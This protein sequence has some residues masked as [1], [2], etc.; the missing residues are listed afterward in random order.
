MNAKI[1]IFLTILLIAILPACAPAASP[2]QPANHTNVEEVQVSAAGAPAPTAASLAYAQSEAAANLANTQT[3]GAVI[4]SNPQAAGRMVIKDAEIE[5]LVKDSAQAIARVTQLAADQGGYIISSQSGYANGYQHA[6]LRLGIP[7]PAFENTM[8]ILR[9]LGIKVLKETAS[10]QDVSSEYAD[11]Q[12][13]LVNLE[14]TSARVRGFLDSAKTVEESLRINQTLS[15]L[16]GQI[17]Q[18]KGQM[19]YYEGRSAYSTVTVIITPQIEE[20]TP[21]P[22]PTLAWNPGT[23]LEDAT[24]VLTSMVQA[25]VDIAIWLVVVLG[26]VALAAFAV[27]WLALFI[28]RMVRRYKPSQSQE[29]SHQDVSG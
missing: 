11:L 6:T 20:M 4:S 2:T 13:R 1:T 28:L 29:G 3:E 17:E 18:V 23:T 27:F 16:E 10:G 21:E 7:S 9:N 15:D 14:A 22:T 25:S 24:S 8:N 26:P 5:L 12:S 19:K